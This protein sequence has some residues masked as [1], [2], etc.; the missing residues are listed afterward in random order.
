MMDSNHHRR[1]QRPGSYQLD[2]R[3]TENGPCPLSRAVSSPVST[4]YATLTPNKDGGAQL[5]RTVI[6]SDSLVFK[7]SCEPSRT[8]L[9]K[10]RTMEDLNLRTPFR[11]DA[12]AKHCDQPLCQ[13]SIKL[14]ESRVG[15]S[16]QPGTFQGHLRLLAGRGSVGNHRANDSS[17]CP[18]A[19][20]T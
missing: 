2:E 17:T 20:R 11:I 19:L 14:L 13:S 8:A 12:L 16:L 1:F 18:T 3:A 4:E 15:D 5:S 9:L 6:L 7:T 10:W